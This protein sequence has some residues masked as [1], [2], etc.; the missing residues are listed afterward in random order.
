VTRVRWQILVLLFFATTIC[1][2]DRIVFSVLMPIIRGELHL[3]EKIYGWINASFQ[4]AYMIGFLGAGRLI[5]RV[6]TRTGYAMAAGWWAAASALHSTVTGPLTLGFWRAMLGLGESGNF[7]SAIKSVAEWFPVKDR[8]FAT[9]I[10]NAGSNVA[11]M[12]G[13]PAFVQIATTVG[14]RYCFLL[15]ASFDCIWIAMWLR[16]YHSPD[17][18]PGVNQEELRYIHSDSAAASAE[19]PIGW[20]QAFRFRQTWGFASGKF[21]TDP[22][23]WFYMYWLPLYLYDVRKFNMKE[24][25]WVLPFIYLMADLGSVAG[26]WLSGMLIRRGWER[27]R[28]RKTAMA[29][30]AC[31]MPVS[32]LGVITPNSTMAVLLFSLA[33]AAHQGWSANLYTTT[34]DVFPRPAVASVTGIGGCAGGLGGVIFSALIPGYVIPLLGYTPVFLVMST[35]YLIALFVLDRLMGDLQPIQAQEPRLVPV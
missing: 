18:H 29:I 35:F 4:V 16:H 23:W 34:S 3:D 17:R 21:L 7:P 12:I 32:A 20:V 13:P 15:T 33:V 8:A 1:Y 10:F 19:P 2:L 25:G 14:W 26:G 31:A 11:S 27:G 30:C 28:A 22:V 9:G 24:V 5:D 6:G